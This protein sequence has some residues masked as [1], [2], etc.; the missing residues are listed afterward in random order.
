MWK[1][2]HILN[3][4]VSLGTVGTVM[5]L[6]RFEIRPA[7]IE[8]AERLHELHT[9]SV[10]ALCKDHYSPELI[11]GWLRNRSPAGYL[12]GIEQGQI[13]VVQSGS[14]IVGFGE[15][16]TG[17]IVAVYVDPRFTHLRIGTAIVKHALELARCGHTGPVR[18]EATLN[19]SPFYERLGFREVGRAF[20]RR[21][22][23]SLPVVVMEI[24]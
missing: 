16:K 10:R 23:V 20:V 9:A 22:H 13:F 12:P 4:S 5:N 21:N 15:A 8:E 14:E 3:S 7:H 18:L 1:H 17:W 24:V 6:K 2:F 19:A 11:D